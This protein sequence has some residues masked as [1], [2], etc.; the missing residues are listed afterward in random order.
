MAKPTVHDLAEQAAGNWKRFDSFA[1]LGKPDDSE[2][3]TVVYTSNRDSDLLTE[4]NAAAI[5]AAMEPFTEGDNPDAIAER[6]SHWA[7]GYVDGYSIRVYGEDGEPTA[8][9][10]TWCDIQARLDDYPVLDESDWSER[11]WN[12]TQKNL[13]EQGEYIARK[14][15]LELPDGWQ[16]TVTTWFETQ[17]KYRHELEPVD[18]HGGYPSDEAIEAAFVAMGL[19]EYETADA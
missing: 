5:A 16:Y 19:M 17:R 2:N 7:C 18:G 14:H 12:D 1:W 10:A 3:W 11:E 4:S 8:A 9:F 15:D 6:H 13:T